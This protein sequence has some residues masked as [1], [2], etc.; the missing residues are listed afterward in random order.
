MQE[1][2]IDSLFVFKC[3]LYLKM[4]WYFFLEVFFCKCSKKLA[5]NNKYL[6]KK[7]SR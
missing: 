3:D 7:Y 1:V 4:R 2:K 5:K 6:F